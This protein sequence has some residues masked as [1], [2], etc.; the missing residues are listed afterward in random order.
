MRGDQAGSSRD[1][2]H[3]EEI[4]VGFAVTGRIALVVCDYAEA[5]RCYGKV[6]VVQDL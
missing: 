4:D 1:G 3:K 2:T 6:A 5:L